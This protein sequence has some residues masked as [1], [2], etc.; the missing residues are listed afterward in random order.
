MEQEILNALD[1]FDAVWQRV[2]SGKGG[3]E[4][5]RPQQAPAQNAL[6]RAMALW[7]AY[8]AYAGQTKGEA[9]QRFTQLAEETRA[10]VRALQTEHFLRTGDL[11]RPEASETLQAPG[12]LTGM[13]L[14]YQGE[15]ELAEML[16]KHTSL[17]DAAARHADALR[18]MI[19]ELLRK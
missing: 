9:R 3:D 1:G 8:T 5:S 13:R 17:A 14:A 4:H 2:L 12:V 16:A 19:A 15:R 6:S 18:D 7:A 10:T 11:Y